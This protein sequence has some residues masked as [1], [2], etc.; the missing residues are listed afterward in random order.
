MLVASSCIWIL[1]LSSRWDRFLSIRLVLLI[2]TDRVRRCHVHRC[3]VSSM[4]ISRGLTVPVTVSSSRG[5]L[6]LLTAHGP[7]R[8]GRVARAAVHPAPPAP[9]ISPPPPPVPPVGELTDE[10]SVLDWAIKV[11]D[12]DSIEEIDRPTLMSLIDSEDY[13]A[14]YF[15]EWNTVLKLKPI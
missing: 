4:A 8:T 6:Q 15:C 2:D 7:R 13:L 1:L 9:L 10:N 5:R 11:K 3:T 14:V 12:D